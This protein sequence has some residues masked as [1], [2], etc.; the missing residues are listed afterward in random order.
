MSSSDLDLARALSR[1]LSELPAHAP[2]AAAPPPAAAVEPP[3]PNLYVRIRK[4]GEA[5]AVSVPGA[6]SGTRS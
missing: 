4:P 5:P 6:A 1:L 3:N 2:A